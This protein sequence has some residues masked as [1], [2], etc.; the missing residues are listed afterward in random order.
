MSTLRQQIDE[1][2]LK[3]LQQAIAEGAHRRYVGRSSEALES[4]LQSRFQSHALLANCGTSAVELALRA[5]GVVPGDEII[6]AGYD[7][8][9][10]FWVIEQLGCV[11]VLVDVQ[12]DS[13]EI[14]LNQLSQ[15]IASNKVRAC[16]VSHL[17]GQL[18]Q[19][20]QLR[21]WAD[22]NQIILVE[23]ACQSL[24][25]EI[26]GV[27]LGSIGHIG[28]LS[29][30]GSKVVSAG[31][32]GALITRDERLF[33]KAKIASGT[34]SGAYGLSELTAAIVTAQL[35]YLEAINDRSANYFDRLQKQ[36]QL[37]VSAA[38]EMKYLLGKAGARDDW[39]TEKT[40]QTE[41]FQTETG[42]YRSG[43]YQA[44][45]VLQ[46]S[47]QCAN[48]IQR[49]KHLGVAAGPGFVGFH[50]RSRRRCR[51]VGELTNTASLVDR[52]LVIHHSVAI[53]ERFSSQ[54]LAEEITRVLR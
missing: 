21:E 42:N 47:Q 1:A 9:G 44:G 27:P 11:P 2:I 16:V 6:I 40:K 10:N 14:D 49:L 50:R 17:H 43:L 3:Q 18:Q 23:D 22:A 12:C 25:A 30:S 54:Q 5:A 20:V 31:R 41:Q 7:Y 4:W 38:T 45:W 24:G 37:N 32:G 28:V 33:Q 19:I 29:F 36:V 8:P 51:S 26:D 48:V 15:A 34:G 39:Q 13:T 35:P 46:T 52:L 53:D